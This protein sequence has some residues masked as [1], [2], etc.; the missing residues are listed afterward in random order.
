MIKPIIKQIAW[1][2]ILFLLVFIAVFLFLF[3]ILN[4][5]YNFNI[6]SVDI[7]FVVSLAASTVISLA[8]VLYVLNNQKLK[9]TKFRLFLSEKFFGMILFCFVLMFISISIKPEIVWK[10]E[11]LK[12]FISIQWAIFGLSV[13]IFLVWEVIFSRLLKE[14]KPKKTKGINLLEEIKYINEK[15]QYRDNISQKYFLVFY[16]ILNVLILLPATS[17]AYIPTIDVTLFDQSLIVGSFYICTNTFL[18]LLLDIIMPILLE[19][20]EAF[21]DVAVTKFD[22]DIYNKGAKLLLEYSKMTEQ[23]DK[24][25]DLDEDKKKEIKNI[26]AA[27][28]YKELNPKTNESDSPDSETEKNGIGEK[29]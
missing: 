3:S 4:S 19:K 7:L 20:K 1:V 17:S 23:I 24:L 21:S 28:L 6:I 26:L 12:E 11:E 10:K 25:S 2:I 5:F 27:V 22:I 14:Q 9:L 29:P 15:K 13:T 16:F 18:Q 8:V